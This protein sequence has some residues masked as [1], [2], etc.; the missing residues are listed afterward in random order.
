[1]PH[2]VKSGW[3]TASKTPVKNRDLWTRLR[4]FDDALSITWTW[5]QGHAGH[6]WN[7]RCDS[8][9][10]QERLNSARGISQG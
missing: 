5:V 1:M 8:L 10:L 6:K 9:V 3:R 2:W 4:E 7:E